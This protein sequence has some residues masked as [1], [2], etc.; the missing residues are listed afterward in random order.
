[1]KTKVYVSWALTAGKVRDIA[2]NYN[3]KLDFH[4]SHGR[5]RFVF[6]LT[7]GGESVPLNGRT[8]KKMFTNRQDVD[9]EKYIAGVAALMPHAADRSVER[10]LVE[11]SKYLVEQEVAYRR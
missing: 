1:M 5:K 3:C 6:A 7:R 4:W 11:V 10:A 9:A 2:S 8:L